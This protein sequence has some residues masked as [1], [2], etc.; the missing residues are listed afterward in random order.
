[1]HLVDQSGLGAVKKISLGNPPSFFYG[2]TW[3]P[4]SKKIAFTDK[5]LN[6]W[7]ADVEKGTTVKVDTDRYDDPSVQLT[8]TWS[9][10]SKWLTYSKFLEN[11]LR[12]IFVY[13]LETG[14]ASQITEGL[15]DARYPV[16]DKDGK[17]LFFTGST[18]VGLSSGWLDL[19][20]YQHPVLRSVYAVVLKK[21]DKS[22][23]EPESDEEK[24]EEE[25]KADEKKADDKKPDARKDGADKTAETQ[26]RQRTPTRIRKARRKKSPSRSRSIWT[27]SVNAS[28]RCLSSRQ[29]TSRLTPEK[30]ECCS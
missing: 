9:P 13:S 27:E 29:I 6:I 11:H 17:A 2:P 8:V 3:S 16:F 21:G 15:G 30:L 24:T 22:P 28:S 20:S 1:M 7:Y 18:D 4:D 25:K 5:R 23:V 14:K 10:D 19:S 26:T 12:A